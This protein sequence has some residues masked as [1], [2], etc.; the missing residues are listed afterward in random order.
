MEGR[1]SPCLTEE[2]GGWARRGSAGAGG[3]ATEGCGRP[4]RRSL[5]EWA[6]GER[7]LWTEAAGRWRRRGGT[8]TS[9]DGQ[10]SGGG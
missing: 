9:D 6:G 3:A 1:V 4:R 10:G 5:T 8:R 7:P 2:K